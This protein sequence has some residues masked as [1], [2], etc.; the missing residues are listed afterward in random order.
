MQRAAFSLAGLIF[1][2]AV[3]LPWSPC[4]D[5]A[6]SHNRLAT[7]RLATNKLSANRLATNRLATNRLATNGLAADMESAGELL[8]TA[9][10]RELYA[11]MM[12]CALPGGTNIEAVIP[13]A[14]DSCPGCSID[15]P[16]TCQTEVCVFPGSLG[17][18]T[19]WIDHK[20]T[21][22]GQ[23]WISACLFARVNLFTLT[24]GHLAAGETR[25]VERKHSANARSSRSR[26]ARFMGS[27]SP[28]Q[29]SPSSGSPARAKPKPK[30]TVAG[31]SC[32]TVL[33]RIPTIR[34]APSAA[35]TTRENATT[36]HPNLCLTTHAKH[37]RTAFT[38]SVTTSP[39]Q[40]SGRKPRN[41]KKSSLFS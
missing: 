36:T 6:T 29:T 25:R 5:A 2:L 33:S 21:K 1:V 38:R 3:L 28:R 26:R 19:K 30:A 39:A 23:R 24:V 18:A 11:Y 40:E 41:T 17:L 31:S 27:I 7:N 35:S 22:K 20:L 10:G 13:G 34:H 15:T 12:S 8:A 16:Y 37:P 4:A 14:P 32:A 9:D